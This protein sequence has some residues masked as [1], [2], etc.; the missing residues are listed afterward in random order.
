[1]VKEAMAKSVELGMQTFDQALFQLCEEGRITEEDALRNADSLNELRLRF[2][3][4][5]KNAST[6]DSSSR[7]DHLSLHEDEPEEEEEAPT[8]PA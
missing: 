6:Q 7:I 4:H 3:L 1:M 8:A 2:K 5:S